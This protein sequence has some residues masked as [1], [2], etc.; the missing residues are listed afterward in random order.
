[1]ERVISSEERIRR[2]E[3]IYNRRKM[4]TGVRMQAN[5][6][7]RTTNDKYK[8]YKKLILQIAICFV[9][10]FIFYLI[11]NSNYI[12]SES[13]IKKTREFLTYDI[14]FQNAYNTAI[15]YYNNNIKT[16]FALDTDKENNNENEGEKN[17]ENQS[18]ENT[19]TEESKGENNETNAEQNEETNNQEQGGIG[20]GEDENLETQNESKETNSEPTVQLSQM[21][22]DANEI[23]Q[24]YNLILPLTGYTVTSRYG[25]RTPTDIVSANHKGI[26]IG[27]NEGTVFIAAMSGK[28]ITASAEGSYGTHLFIQNGDVITV[29]AHCKKL[30][31]NEGDEIVQGQKL[32]E[33]GQT[34]NA[35]GPHLHFEIRKDGRTID[36]E[37]ILTFA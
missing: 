1:M 27:A 28:V 20:G 15:E 10:Y 30:Y 24:N 11:K 17:V 31:V 5:A 25:S 34:G 26:D 7:N 9:L 36:P 23:K 4:Q 21:Q 12:F 14:N 29:Y 3:E 8:L 35:T 32:G 6:V 19:N 13:F 2:A 22:I 33:V 37:Y 18:E 16:Y